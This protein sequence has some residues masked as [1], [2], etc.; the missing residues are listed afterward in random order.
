MFDT[1]DQDV[2]TAEEVL[3]DIMCDCH[4]NP[5][6]AKPPGECK[7]IGE[8]KHECCEECIKNHKP[9]PDIG[10]EKG[11]LKNGKPAAPRSSYKPA[12]P[13]GSCFPDACA[14]DA[15]GNPTQF[16]DFKFIC[17]DGTRY[18]DKRANKGMGGYKTATGKGTAD[19]NFYFP[20]GRSQYDKYKKLGKKLY[21]PVKDNPKPL[22]SRSCK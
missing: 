4:R 2:R 6:P 11:Y 7:E 12:P 16:F 22:T 14:T 5:P 3:Q 19:A 13:K 15:A 8:A 1:F 10:G 17:P 9:P 21:P 20:K 18:W